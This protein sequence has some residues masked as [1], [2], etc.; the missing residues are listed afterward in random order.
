MSGSGA[1]GQSSALPAILIVGVIV[2]GV[3]VFLAAGTRSE[4]AKTSQDAGQAPAMI[5]PVAGQSRS[6]AP[7][8]RL[9]NQVDEPPDSTPTAPGGRRAAARISTPNRVVASPA[10]APQPVYVDAEGISTPVAPNTGPV[11][12]RPVPRKD[13]P[14][15]PGNAMRKFRRPPPPP[16]AH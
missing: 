16:T 14:M 13:P 4:Q 1:G 7:E 8:A 11:V 5:P 2:G 15:E 12:V 9:A 10:P 3:V 6:V